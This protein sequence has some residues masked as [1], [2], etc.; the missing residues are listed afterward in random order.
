[1]KN[2]ALVSLVL[3]CLAGCQAA[4]PPE[5][6]PEPE[7]A[8]GPVVAL[9][10][11]FGLQDDAVGLMRGVIHGIA[12]RA[13]IADLTHEVPRF[14]V[15]EGARLLADGPGIYPP[16]S[17][18]CIVVDPGVGTRRQAI[19]ARLPN[20]TY[21]VA[22]DNGV[23]TEAVARHGPAEVRA[24]KNAE[25]L[26]Q[27][28]SS[29]F[30]G[31]DVFAPVAAH[32]A[33]GTPFADVGPTLATWVRI[34]RQEATREGGV[35]SGVVQA[36]DEPFGNVLTNI[37]ARWVEELGVPHGTLLDVSL[38]EGSPVKIP[39]VATFGDVDEGAPLLYPNSRGFLSLALNMG[40]YARAH[41]VERGAAVRVRR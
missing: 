25:L 4:P 11:D 1:M 16:G 41:G 24:I 9:L 39:W 33:A 8:P 38:G 20:G 5:P 29:T 23:I 21:L 30:H 35:M 10:T 37:P 2:A 36:I 34:E 12:P 28:V 15:A 7:P 18:F 40:D 22:P 17:V 3:T 32:L 13:R 31:R 6:E 19:V 26:R 27:Q 14:D